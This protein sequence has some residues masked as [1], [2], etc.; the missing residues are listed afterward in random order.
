MKPR[1]MKSAVLCAFHP[2]ICVHIFELP[3]DRRLRNIDTMAI[4]IFAILGYNIS[5]KYNKSY[6]SYE[7]GLE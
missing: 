2:L 6:F 4:D 7:E 5:N 1:R 3:D